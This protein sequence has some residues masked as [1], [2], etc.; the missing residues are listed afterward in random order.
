M[1]LALAASGLEAYREKTPTGNLKAIIE[2]EET[3][4][5]ALSVKWSDLRIEV[6]QI[7]TVRATRVVTDADSD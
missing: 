6:D 5:T 1:E 7:M 2:E 3:K 4:H